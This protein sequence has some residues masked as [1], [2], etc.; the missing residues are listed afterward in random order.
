M[1][2]AAP[3][4]GGRQ[5]RQQGQQQQGRVRIVLAIFDEETNSLIAKIVVVTGRGATVTVE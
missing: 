2:E 4:V 5:A 3:G 1:P